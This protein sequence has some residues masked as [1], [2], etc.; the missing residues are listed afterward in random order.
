VRL[1]LAALLMWPLLAGAVARDLDDCT[2]GSTP[3]ASAPLDLDNC[4]IDDGDDITG[5]LTG[6]ASTYGDVYVRAPSRTANVVAAYTVFTVDDFY[7]L[8]DQ[9]AANRL[10]INHKKIMPVAKG[11]AFPTSGDHWYRWFW[12]TDESK[13]YRCEGYTAPDCTSWVERTTGTFPYWESSV[14]TTQ[15]TCTSSACNGFFTLWQFSN[16]DNVVIGGANLSL[17]FVGTHPGFANCSLQIYV[18]MQTGRDLTYASLCDMWQGMLDFRMTDGSVATLADVRANVRF[19]Q[20]LAIASAGPDYYHLDTNRTTQFN[21]AGMFYATSGIQINGATTVWADPDRTVLSDPYVRINGWTGGTSGETVLGLPYGC[22]NQVDDQVRMASVSG[23]LVRQ[24]NG[25]FT[26]EYGQFPWVMRLTGRIGTAASPFIVRLKDWGVSGPGTGA[27]A[28]VRPRG[29]GQ[30]ILFKGDP[31]NDLSE[32]PSRF[33]RFIKL[34]DTYGSGLNYN[35]QYVETCGTSIGGSDAANFMRFENNTSGAETRDY[36]FEFAGDW[37]RQPDGGDFV[38]GTELIQFGSGLDTQPNHS[39]TV[40]LAAGTAIP[41]DTVI[42]RDRSTVT[43][44]GTWGNLAV[45]HI[46]DHSAVGTLP[47]CESGIASTL[48]NSV[49]VTWRFQTSDNRLYQCYQSGTWQW[50]EVPTARNSTITDTNVSGVITVSANTEGTT[51]SNVNFTG[52]ARAV[53]TVGASAD[54]TVTD[55][56]VP[57]GSTITGTGTLTYEGSG[58]SLPYTIPNSTSNCAITADPRPGPVTGGGVE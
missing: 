46:A 26:M 11:S 28:G 25:G 21:V 55:L 23:Y 48:W 47:T 39:H 5:I 35:T 54:V 40:R 10:T 1:I 4:D 8:E 7:F 27:S 56:C 6:L 14:D 50:R 3:T 45:T 29:T 18:N 22:S 49:Y 20:H 31:A 57:N 58:Q 38:R 24:F 9:S 13:M 2:V 53:I 43:G 30:V 12:R 17:T 15:A 41:A 19:S 52:T 32:S 34:P 37:T 42:L 44:P 51:V 36:W 16:Y 33:V